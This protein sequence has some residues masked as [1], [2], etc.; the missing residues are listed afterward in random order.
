MRKIL[1]KINRKLKKER[2][3]RLR[4][5]RAEILAKIARP[6]ADLPVLSLELREIEERLRKPESRNMQDNH[7]KPELDEPAA[8]KGGLGLLE[9]LRRRRRSLH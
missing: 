7:K 6:G 9:P 8:P 2:L 3:L 4:A 1:A 5:A